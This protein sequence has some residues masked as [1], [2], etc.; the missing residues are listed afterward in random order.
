MLKKDL[1]EAREAIAGVA[2]PRV[3]ETWFDGLSTVRREAMTAEWK[4][5]LSSEVDCHEKAERSKLRE[6]IEFGT[7]FMLFEAILFGGNIPSSLLGFV[8]GS[9]TGLGLA[10]QRAERFLCCFAGVFG[11]VG[12]QVIAGGGFGVFQCVGFMLLACACAYQGLRR[13]T[14]DF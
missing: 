12:L 11:F 13:E 5:S 6:A 1:A 10:Q 4:E 8:L 14:A 7:I 9:A 2:D 3:G